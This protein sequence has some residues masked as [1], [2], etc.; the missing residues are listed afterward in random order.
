MAATLMHIKSQ[1]LLPKDEDE[2]AEDDPRVPLVAQLL[3]YERFQRAAQELDLIPWLG[4]DVFAR[5]QAASKD[6]IPHEA[7][8]D[9][10]IDPLDPYALLMGLKVAMDRTE[11]P[12][13]NVESDTTSLR[14]KVEEMGTALDACDVSELSRFIPERPVRLEIIV[15][16]LSVLELTRLKFIE[17]IQTENFGPIQIRRVRSLSELNVALLDTF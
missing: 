6:L 1:L 10:P 2:E 14:E 17:I 16:F 11:K 9:A 15:A 4:R 12:T 7:L 8:M 5:P 3:E 13:H